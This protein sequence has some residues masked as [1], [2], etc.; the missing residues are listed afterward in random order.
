MKERLVEWLKNTRPGLMEW[1]LDLT[2]SLRNTGSRRKDSLSE[3]Q[4]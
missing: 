2:C 3:E 1:I 4:R